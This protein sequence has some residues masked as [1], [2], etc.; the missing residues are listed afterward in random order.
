[1]ESGRK[2]LVTTCLRLKYRLILNTH[3]TNSCTVSHVFILL[4][5]YFFALDA[6]VKCTVKIENVNCFYF[7]RPQLEVGIGPIIF[8]KNSCP[9]CRFLPK[10]TETIS[11]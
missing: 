8:Y 3:A 9:T 4:I 10:G 1:M 6:A 5:G 7:L 11:M 2:S